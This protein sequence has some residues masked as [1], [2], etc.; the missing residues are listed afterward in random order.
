MGKYES[1][2]QSLRDLRIELNKIL[3]ENNE[4]HGTER[5]DVRE[6]VADD[7]GMKQLENEIEQDLKCYR[8]QIDKSQLD[9]CI[10]AV[11]LRMK[12]WDKE[13]YPS[14][15][16]RP[17][18]T[19]RS[20]SPV[21]NLPL[22]EYRLSAGNCCA[23]FSF[24]QSE[25]TVDS[26][27]SDNLIHTK[28]SIEST[29]IWKRL[30]ITKKE[31]L[32]SW[33]FDSR[34]ISCDCMSTQ[35]ILHPLEVKC[36]ESRR[37]QIQLVANA[38][39]ESLR[40][41]N[42]NFIRFRKEKVDIMK[43]IDAKNQRIE[44]MAMNIGVDYHWEVLSLQEDEIPDRALSFRTDEVSERALNLKLKEAERNRL[45]KGNKNDSTETSH[46]VQK[47]LNDMMYG[48]LNFKKTVSLYSLVFIV[49]LFA[50]V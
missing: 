7:Q 47:A 46:E 25:C 9:D 18:Q 39:D 38:I 49:Y 5:I 43:Q 48:V 30:V 17:F 29:G 8:D 41:F 32:Q 3:E 4:K 35:S 16:I 24:N 28:N 31:M 10:E 44:G 40:R 15:L 34:N 12:F 6:I 20:I 23:K 50:K 21:R 19:S 45:G 11:K 2:K 37:K 14:S 13:E 1:M 26:N 22:Q 33:K 27:V 42:E 36:D